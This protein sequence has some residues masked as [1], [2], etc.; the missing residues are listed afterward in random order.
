[1]AMRFNTMA[2]LT[3]LAMGASAAAQR[4]EVKRDEGLQPVLVELFTS[5]GCS[6]CPPSG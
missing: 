2:G 4:P 5:E 3:L 1:M 6:S